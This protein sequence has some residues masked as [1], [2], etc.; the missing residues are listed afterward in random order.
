MKSAKTPS[1]NNRT[2]DGGC[3]EISRVALLLQDYHVLSSSIREREIMG[4]PCRQPV[5]HGFWPL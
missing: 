3:F 2:N 1:D 5:L 4:N